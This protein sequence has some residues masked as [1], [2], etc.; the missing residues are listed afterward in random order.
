MNNGHHGALYDQIEADRNH[1]RGL[2]LA[3][4]WGAFF[5]ASSVLGVL[6]PTL[7]VSLHPLFIVV[8]F[9]LNGAPKVGTCPIS[10]SLQLL[11]MVVRTE[12]YGHVRRKALNAIMTTF[13]LNTFVVLFYFSTFPAPWDD[14]ECHC[15]WQV[16][17]PILGYNVPRRA[18]PVAKE[19]F[20]LPATD[21]GFFP[22]AGPLA[23]YKH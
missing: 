19:G 17:S 21:E 15:W 13:P 4:V 10:P 20:F 3:T 12:K 2:V 14:R 23:Q 22:W 5:D 1:Q 11:G 16:T 6:R 7:S 18:F 9:L 8:F